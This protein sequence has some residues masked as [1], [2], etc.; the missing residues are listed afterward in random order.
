MED[1][2]GHKRIKEMLFE[3]SLQPL[4]IYKP[5][6]LSDRSITGQVLNLKQLNKRLLNPNNQSNH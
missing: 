2:P 1:I 5:K 6:L 3:P 4:H